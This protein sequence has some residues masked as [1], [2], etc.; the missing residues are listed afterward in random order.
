VDDGSPNRSSKRYFGLLLFRNSIGV[1]EYR[2]TDIPQMPSTGGGDPQ[3]LG[4]GD[5]PVRCLNFSIENHGHR[6]AVVLGR[7]GQVEGECDSLVVLPRFG[8][9]RFRGKFL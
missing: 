2:V 8:S 1:F 9:V 3:R 6:N 7:L 5:P 4:P